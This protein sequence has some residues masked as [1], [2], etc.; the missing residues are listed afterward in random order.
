M[1]VPGKPQAALDPV[2]LPEKEREWLNLLHTGQT[3][4]EEVWLCL[5]APSCERKGCVLSGIT[6]IGGGDGAV[7]G[8]KTAPKVGQ[9]EEMS[10]LE[11][12]GLR[13]RGEGVGSAACYFCLESLRLHL[14]G[15][16]LFIP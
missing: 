5:D 15:E 2:E 7:E 6:Q 10:A 8:L 9:E 14:P 13:W 1:W 3:T 16:L 4:L 11:E 12:K